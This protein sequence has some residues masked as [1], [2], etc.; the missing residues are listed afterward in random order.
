MT[1]DNMVDF[2]FV[3]NAAAAHL[4]AADHLL[5]GSAVCGQCYFITNG[6]PVLFWDFVSYVL[7]Q[8]GCAGPEKYISYS[9]AYAFAYVMEWLQYLFG[10]AIRVGPTITRQMVCTM[11]QHHWF[12]HAKATRDF[13][14]TPLVSLDQALQ[15]TIAHFADLKVPR[16]TAPSPVSVLHRTLSAQSL[17]ALAR[18]IGNHSSR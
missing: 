5:P 17:S 2:T 11:S 8:C 1:G 18:L 10:W 14:Y 9:M 6:E 16:P 7:A 12:S 4:R 15:V 3:E 13:G